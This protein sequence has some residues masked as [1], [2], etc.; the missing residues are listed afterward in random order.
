MTKD[1]AI[2]CAKNM[3][4]QEAIRNTIYA[5]GVR[6]KKATRI[7]L[8]E[9]AEIADKIDKAEP[10][11][12]LISR[13]ELLK[14]LDRQIEWEEANAIPYEDADGGCILGLKKAREYVKLA[15]STEKPIANDCDLISREE[16]IEALC[17]NCAYY[18]DAQCKT[19]S[20]YWCESGAMIRELPEA[21]AVGVGRYENAMQKL[22]EMP[23]YLNGI[24]AKQI[25]KISAD[26]PKG[27]WTRYKRCDPVGD[28]IYAVME[29]PDG[30]FF[31]NQCGKSAI[32]SDFCPHCGADMKGEPE[33][34]TEP[35]PVVAYICDRRRCAICSGEDGGCDHTTDI[36]HAAHFKNVA[37]QYFERT[38]MEEEE[39]GE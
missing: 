7:K 37:G 32:K 24:K 1:E 4:Y 22:R 11:G 33:T 23:R 8:H 25:K 38:Y 39:D 10:S 35:A 6:Y 19:D 30:Q 28:E 20:G 16:A 21:E 2:E 34:E 14:K 13:E 29:A 5:K 18:T 12:E 31:C 9:L 17:H 15:S 3:T 27:K 36:K 26:R